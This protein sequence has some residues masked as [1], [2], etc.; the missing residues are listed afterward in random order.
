M[1]RDEALEALP[2]P[3]GQALILD[4]DGHDHAAIATQIDVP[5]DAVAMLLEVGQVKLA[6]LLAA[7]ADESETQQ[8][9]PPTIQ[10]VRSSR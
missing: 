5:L 9:M 8:E 4:A 10:S 3:Y 1:D 2:A 7:D 6:A